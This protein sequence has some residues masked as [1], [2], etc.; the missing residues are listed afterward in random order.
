MSFFI[1]SST[2][3]G[4]KY[5]GKEL[6]ASNMYSCAF[7]LPDEAGRRV[8]FEVRGGSG[9]D[10]VDEEG[11]EEVFECFG[12]GVGSLDEETS[13]LAEDWVKPEDSGEGDG[14]LRVV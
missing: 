14:R 13:W 9:K 12:L 2:S 10:V 6:L 4:T 5:K 7:V 3:L 1:R 11:R 8:G